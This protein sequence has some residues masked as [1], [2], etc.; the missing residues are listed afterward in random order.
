MGKVI[1]RVYG[2][3][4]GFVIQGVCLYRWIPGEEGAQSCLG[5]FLRA[6]LSGNFMDTVMKAVQRFPGSSGY[7]AADL[8]ALAYE[9]LFC[10]AFFLVA[11]LLCI[12]YIGFSFWGKG[13]MFCGISMIALNLSLYQGANVLI[14]LWGGPKIEIYL[15]ITLLTVAATFVGAR[16]LEDIGKANRQAKALKRRDKRLKKERKRRLYFPGSYSSLFYHIIL[17]NCRYR[18]R[19]YLIFLV[20]GSMAVS[21]LVAGFGMWALLKGQELNQILLRF[22]GIASVISIFLIVNVLLFYLKNRMQSYRILMNLGMRRMTLRAYMTV[23]LISCMGITVLAG[24]IVGKIILAIC[25]SVLVQRLGAEI[26]SGEITGKVWLLTSGSI[27]GV[28][29]V[30]LMLTRDN[31]Y[32]PEVSGTADKAVVAEPVGIRHCWLSTLVGGAAVAA[33]IYFYCQKSIAESAVPIG[34]FLFGLYFLMKTFWGAGLGHVRKKRT[35][36]YQHLMEMNYQYY[37]FRTMFRYMFFLSVLHIAVLFFFAGD[38]AS[39]ITAENADGLF[40]YDYVCI[41]DSEDS[42]CFQH[43]ETQGLI[44]KKE[45]PMV[46]VSTPDKEPAMESRGEMLIPGTH[47]GISQ[48]VYRELCKEV[49]KTPEDLELPKDGSEVHIVYQQDRNQKAHPLDYYMLQS[50]P[51]IRIGMPQP[52]QETEYKKVYPE[53]QIEGE[54]RSILTGAF[55]QGRQE[56]IVVFADGCLENVQYEGP[57]RLLLINLTG[58]DARKATEEVLETYSKRHE[59]EVSYDNELKTVYSK[60][61]FEPQVSKSRILETTISLFIIVILVMAGGILFYIKTESEMEE[62]RKQH[63]FLSLVGMGPKE[64]HHIIHREL[65][66][67]C[68]VPLITA[69]IVTGGFLCV[70]LQM[71]LFE[72]SDLL[73]YMKFFTAFYAGYVILQIGGMFLLDRYTIGKVDRQ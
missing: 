59:D 2:I 35:F 26:L 73:Q 61:E 36:F 23:E 55:L 38:I 34:L 21:F 50:V 63:V 28:F 20:T 53:R 37:R 15:L 68:T 62:R 16:L 4:M 24:L 30:S 27:G 9:F 47:I 46:R 31:Y 3:I 39:A 60:K 57:D 52:A 64:R 42:E 14:S 70:K 69:T 43:L 66:S 41:A 29:L 8:Q 67:Y 56:N 45:Y 13:L 11:Q 58:E 17:E 18:W 44:R 12:I 40:P 54:E 51:C 48:S 72:F 49:G 5:F 19:D 32:G 25:T 1:R 6:V 7:D 10:V 65:F 33:G 22:I 71:R